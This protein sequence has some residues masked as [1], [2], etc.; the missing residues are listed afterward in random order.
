[1]HREI[2]KT[3]WIRSP[4]G[5]HQNKSRQQRVDSSIRFRTWWSAVDGTVQIWRL[6]GHED[7]RQERIPQN[8]VRNTHTYYTHTCIHTKVS[9]LE[10]VCGGTQTRRGEGGGGGA[11]TGYKN[12]QLV[13]TSRLY[14]PW[15]MARCLIKL[16]YLELLKC[17]VYV[18]LVSCEWH[19]KK[20][21]QWWHSHEKHSKV[22]S[23]FSSSHNLNRTFHITFE[24]LNI[25]FIW[26]SNVTSKHDSML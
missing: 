12:A 3:R 18:G 19:R 11:K 1:M 8:A 24:F 26:D 20:V 10:S 5:L 23:E 16:E 14:P 17:G 13:T 2:G 4:P 21:R 7:K 15:T 6:C 9:F 22:W 25:Y